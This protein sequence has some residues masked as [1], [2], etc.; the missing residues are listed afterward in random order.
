VI[1]SQVTLD[2]MVDEGSRVMQ[3]DT[4]CILGADRLEEEYFRA[5]DAYDIARAGYNKSKADLDLEYAMLESQVNIID[6][7]TAITR[8]DSLQLRF[9]SPLEKKRIGLELEKA[10]VKRQKIVDKLRFLKSINESEM[11]KKKLQIDMQRNRIDRA[12]AQLNK[13]VLT[14]PVN[15][16]VTYANSWSTGEKI[17]VGDE[18]WQGMPLLE[19]PQMD[20]MQVKLFAG[21]TAFKQVKEGQEARVRVDAVPGM[22]LNGRIKRKA[23]M[24]KP[25]RRGSRVKV[26]EII[27][28]LDSAK[29][30]VQPGLSVSCEVFI[31]RLADTL[32]IPVISIFEEDSM[33][34]V[35][36]QEG[37]RFIRQPVEIAVSNNRFA[38][39]K[40]GLSGRERIASAKPPASLIVD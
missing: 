3:G 21:E 18:V 5:L 7:S 29:L 40:S 33:K 6:I 24:G 19:I 23:P 11:R 4:V 27:A 13:L 8:L 34:V 17:A 36:V 26:F 16:L 38:V 9:T 15:G 12:V 14:S 30:A 28:S 2:W 10:E 39:I 20:E 22:V 37:K 32:V 25:L 1:F 35:Y 31:N